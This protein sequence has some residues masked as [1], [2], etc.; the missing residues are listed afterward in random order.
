MTDSPDFTTISSLGAFS[1]SLPVE[2]LAVSIAFYEKLGFT[3]MGGDGESW[4]ILVNGST[5]VGL[6]HGMFDKPMLT[7][8]PGWGPGASE[9]PEFTDVR[10]VRQGL[11]DHGMPVE[12]DT[13]QDSNAGPASF[14]VIDP[15]GNPILIDQ[16]R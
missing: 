7:F 4:I 6:F 11:I 14:M 9:L 10:Q 1:I 5:T 13:T 3:A 2:D 16:H 12:G 15:D 8:N